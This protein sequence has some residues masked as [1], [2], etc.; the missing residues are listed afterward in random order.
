METSQLPPV[1][2]YPEGQEPEQ[3]P[4]T[5]VPLSGPMTPS[6]IPSPGVVKERSKKIQEGLG[7]TLKSSTDEI[8]DQINQGR[9]NNLRAI[10]ASNL[11]SEQ[12]L[13]KLDTLRGLASQS[14]T[15][16]NEEEVTRVMDPFN[17]KPI[18]PDSVVEKQYGLK[19][20]GSLNDALDVFPS[21]INDAKKEVPE[22]VDSAF[23][24][25]SELVAKMEG[26][27]KIRED[28]EADIHAQSWPGYI[29]DQTKQMFQPYNEYQLRGNVPGVGGMEGI[30]LGENLKAQADAIIQMPLDDSL[31]AT[32][33]A[34]DNLKSNPTLAHRF[35]SYV[36]GSTRDDRFLD[37]IFTAMAPAD[38]AAIGRGGLNVAR[39]LSLR[40]RTNTAIKGYI[41]QADKVGT[42]ASR[43]AE[44]AGD[45]D[46]A[47]TTRSSELVQAQI[48]GKADPIGVATDETLLTFLNQDKQKIAEKPGNLTRE[49]VTRI[50]DQYDAS[51]R[52][53]L[54]R[55]VDAARINRIPMALATQN[56][57]NVVRESIKSYYPGLRN[58]ILDISNPIYEPR[59]NTYWHD[60]TF[61]NFGGTLF[62]NPETAANF[63]RVHGFSDVKI[64]SGKGLL[65]SDELQGLLTQQASIKKNI[66]DAESGLSLNTKKF[67]D[68]ATP[69]NAKAQAKEQVDLFNSYKR[70]QEKALN[71]VELRLKGDAYYDRVSSLQN[72]VERLRA[73]NKENGKFLRRTD[74]DEEGKRI[75]KAVSENNLSRAAEALQEIRAVRAGKASV[76]GGTTRVEQQGLGFKIVIRRP[77]N[78][79]DKTIRDLMI[80]DSN[81]NFIPEAL[82]TGSSG[83]WKSLMNAAIGKFRGADDTLALNESI[84]RKIGTYTQSLF[85]EW[86]QQEAQYIKQIASGVIRTDPV[87]GQPIPYWRAKPVSYLNKLSKPY[88]DV[89]T[90]E[91]LTT[92]NAFTRTLDYARDAKDPYTGKPGY[93]FQTP[94]E[95]NDHYLRNYDVSPSFTEH[96][97]YFAFVRM[98]EGD[99]IMREIAEFR[100]RARLGVESFSLTQALPGNTRTT[101]KSPFFDGRALKHFPGGDGV[102][103][104]MGRR[105]GEE[106]LVNLGGAGITPKQIEAYRTAIEQG[107]LTAIEVYAPEHRPLREYSDIAGNEIVRY[108]LTETADRKPIEFKNVNRRGGGHFEYDYDHFIKQPDMYHQYENSNGIKGKFKSSYIG[109]TTFMPVL[110]RVMGNDIVKHLHT[111]RDF[112]KKG[113]LDEAKSYTEANLPIEWKDL[114]AM[115]K[116][117][118]DENGKAKPASLSL[119]E[120]F[121]VVPKGKTILDLNK[122]LENKYGKSFID[123]AKSG[124][125]N[126]QFQVAYNTER[127]SSG[128]SH[129]EDVGT[130]D[131]PLYRYAPETKMVDPITTMNRSLNR[132]VNTVFMDD[133]KMYAVEHWLREAETHLKATQSEINASPFW[134]FEN[135]QDKSAFKAGT[136][137]ETVQNLLSNRY[138][139][140]QFVGVPSTFDTA[141]HSAKQ[142]L[143][144]WSY[145]S[146][147]PEDSRNIFQKSITILPNWMLGK[148]SDPVQFIRS[149]TFHEKLGLFNPAQLL[150]QAQT[151]ANI[152]AIAGIEN[153]GKGTSGAFL[154]QWSRMNANPEILQSLGRY[155]EKLG[156]KPGEWQEAREA[157]M[158]TGFFNVAGEH[159]NLNTAM[160]TDFV[161]NDFKGILNAGT[162]F[163]S[164][165]ERSTRLGAWYTAYK[166]FRD[167]RPV[168]PVT[169]D[170]LGK[171]LQ[172]AD[173]LTVN[174]SRA[175]NS[176]INSGVMSLT[177]QFLNYQIR[178]AELF[179]GTRLGATTS[180]RVMARTRILATYAAL[181]GAPSAI[182]VT[183]LPLTSSIRQEAIERGYNVG[184]NWLSTA[185]DQGLP[186]I[187]LALITGK[188]DFRKG[189][190]YN[191]GDRLGS[192]GFTQLSDAMKSDHAWWQLL[193]GAAGTTLIDQLTSTSNF[194]RSMGSMLKPNNAD[195]SFPLMLD[196]FVDI[197]KN[198]SSVN[199]AWKVIAAVHTGKWMSKNEGYI[200]DVSKANAA[201]M[202]ITGLSPQQQDDA[203][204][205]SNIRKSEEEYQKSVLKDFIKE[206]RRGIQAARDGDQS[207][208]TK[209]YR[210]AFTL[211]EIT[212]YPTEKKATAMALAAQGNE[213][214]IKDQ[215]YSFATKMVPTSK[216]TLLGMPTPF[217]TQSNVPDVRREQLRR[218]LQL[219]QYKAQ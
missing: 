58:A 15:P 163:F 41:Q 73:E 217:Q 46:T 144:D 139:I 172:R 165:G 55:I 11:Q 135:A 42:D 23:L 96:Q 116:P 195:K 68:P 100:N 202:A 7:G 206:Y 86:A 216:S 20:V 197:F 130:V 97:A 191:I 48:E 13:Q 92:Y 176:A 124:S 162:F 117:G 167:L 160:K 121:Y 14:P 208:A 181:Y 175:S 193:A 5:G 88:T 136:P 89:K 198:I 64:S 120:D 70:E 129:L 12:Y 131:N 205:K 128:L 159:A 118:R 152:Y 94:G 81:G 101:T 28:L 166:E 187:A 60:V 161:G 1:T 95:L 192:P 21:Q 19:Y 10:A 22:E 212:G 40:S 56:A 214:L 132:I 207:T 122:D 16:L 188:G 17:S 115:F 31:K 30:G 25:G 213:S 142:T 9:E 185:I 79:T 196:D 179:M 35:I 148:T 51:G 203:Y 134:H 8:F 186:A 66:M 104:I 76:I 113:E 184:D 32:R 47:A 59:S 133:Y 26:Y 33:A 49:Q 182:G 211:L 74:V 72:E 67:T 52:T 87:T 151:Y 138:K 137:W 109:D 153:A 78:E 75:V 112:I 108:V 18:N 218:Q 102:L 83:G 204:I 155:A 170:D 140:K 2:I 199:Q 3:Q 150:V 82:S 98:V 90:Q 143:V 164:E 126:K 54:Q 157:A 62:S 93:F 171:I 215:D 200:G 194:F 65:A 210:R 158:K 43:R 61:G 169:K 114:S 201:F 125:L 156:W 27:R 105:T 84:N 123:N 44:V 154:H 4:D 99:R 168:G 147:G 209:S 57:I 53:L 177:T 29:W 34:I 38:Y 189:N 45:L 91:K 111:I 85:K 107:K 77:L 37:N 50:Q 36:E 106:K 71:D 119:D 127:E 180:E 174:M 183:G 69:A 149:M 103:M 110:N 190:N 173:L 6:P 178:M 141:I 145:R 63:A 219:N 24:K 39:N 80:K 146:F